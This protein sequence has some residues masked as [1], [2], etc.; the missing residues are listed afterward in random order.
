MS[1]FPE[2]EWIWRDGE[3]VRWQDAQIHVLSTAVQFGASV[4]EGIRCYATTP[5]ADGAKRPPAV[6]RLREHLRRMVDSCRIYRIDLPHSLDLLTD[7]CL[8]TLEKNGL[9]DAYLRPTVIR[10]YG[11]AGMMP[12]H[13]PIET[14]I[15]CWPW[16]AYLG[17]EAM[18]RGA[19]FQVSTWNRPAPNTFPAQAKV[20]GHY[21]NA[22]LMKMEAVANGYDE[23]IALSPDGRVS[24]GSGQNLFCV[25]DG[26]VITPPIEG[27]ALNG[28]TRDAV[29][30]IARDLGLTVEE[31]AVPRE[32]LYIADEVFV[33]GTAS[34]VTPVRSIDRIAIG[35]GS[36]GEITGAIQQ[37]FLQIVKGE[38]P[39]DHGWRTEV[40]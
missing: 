39:D 23:A 15:A 27:T 1:G 38:A 24:E 25:R 4:F 40:V 37:R 7:A 8:A 11:D 36:R 17:Q 3:F 28:I 35:C 20:A 31:R 33:T 10:G 19:D 29:I 32:F 34:E 22:Q 9:E 18:E 5:G 12:Q 14:F 26:I 6:F 21:T 13:S 16:G 30:R 2:V